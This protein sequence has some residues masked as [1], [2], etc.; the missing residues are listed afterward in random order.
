MKREHKLQT[1]ISGTFTAVF[2]HR[3]V[4]ENE[5]GKYLADIGRG[6]VELEELQQ[7]DKVKLKGER[8]SS[9]IKVTEIEN[10][11]GK[12][13][14][15]EHKEKHGH[16]ERHKYQ[17]PRDA[18]AA[19]TR[20]GFEVTGEPRRKPTHFQILGRSAKGSF[21]E[22]HVEFDGRI[23]NRRPADSHKSKWQSWPVLL[24]DGV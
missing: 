4:I 12:R 9:E 19:V 10:G 21:T 1:S 18:I 17:D 24:A 20:E 11:A 23:R 8:T 6:L 13:M 2:T 14:C 5:D 22:F 3:F 7:G 15:I 16:G